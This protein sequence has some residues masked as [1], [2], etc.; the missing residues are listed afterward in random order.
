M[1]RR[2]LVLL[3]ACALAATAAGC[4]GNATDAQKR[5]RCAKKNARGSY[6]ELGSL[7]SSVPFASWQK[8][9]RKVCAQ[10]VR[11]GK[12]SSDGG[13]M[14]NADVKGLIRRHP[15]V[16]YPFCTK[17]GLASVQQLPPEAR[18]Y[19]T[20]AQLASYGKD[21]C[22]VAFGSG[23][24]LDKDGLTDADQD[25]IL[26]SN[27]RLFLPFCL[28]GA[29]GGYDTDPRARV[30]PKPAF[31]KLMTSVCV[32]ASSR[33]LITTKGVRDQAAFTALVRKTAQRMRASGQL[34]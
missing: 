24:A 3:A 27:P 6:D 2:A 20:R 10:G 11:E 23:K 33:G 21:Y 30:I 9:I 12:V 31:R 8:T 15:E 32:Q 29:L 5:D 13:G 22:D 19:V 7:K 16:F 28:A 14:S 25:A 18:K 34:R 26:R 17:V 4:G 1:I